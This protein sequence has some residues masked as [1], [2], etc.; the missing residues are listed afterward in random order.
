MQRRPVRMANMDRLNICSSCGGSGGGF[1]TD[2]K[3]VFVIVSPCRLYGPR[4]S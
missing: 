1:Q 4:N 3:S 2:E